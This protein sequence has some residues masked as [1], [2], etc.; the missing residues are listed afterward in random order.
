MRGFSVLMGLRQDHWNPV[1]INALRLYVGFWG[2]P[3]GSAAEL[4]D[5]TLKLRYCTTIFTKQFPPW[6]LPW[7]GKSVGKRGAVTSGNHLDCRGN[8]GKRVRL[9]RKTRPGA[10][11]MFIPDPGH[12]TLKRWKRLRLPSSEGVEGRGRGGRGVRWACLAIFFLDFGLGEVCT[13]GPL[14][15]A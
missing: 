3:K 9:T 1:I 8:F 6:F 12:P 13:R 14:E 15:Q 11:S 5:G 4:L 7:L 10:S 2:I